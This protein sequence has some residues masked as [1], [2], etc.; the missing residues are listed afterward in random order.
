MDPILVALTL[1]REALTLLD[2]PRLASIG[3]YI[4]LAINE[5]ERLTEGPPSDILPWPGGDDDGEDT[6]S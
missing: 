5:A 1:M 2:E 4:S 3:R 6:A